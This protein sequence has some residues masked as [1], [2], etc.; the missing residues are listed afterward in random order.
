MTVTLDGNEIPLWTRINVKKDQILEIGS[1]E[2]NV[3]G[4]RAYLAIFGGIDIPDY[5]GSKST[6]ISKFKKI[7][8]LF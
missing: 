7:E 3:K 4:I 2:E 1:K 5:L 8:F 6:F